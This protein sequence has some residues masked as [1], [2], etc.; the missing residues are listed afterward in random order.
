LLANKSIPLCK[1]AK[2]RVKLAGEVEDEQKL[3]IAARKRDKKNELDPDQDRILF[4]DAGVKDGW[5]EGEISD[6]G[7]LFSVDYD[8]VP[9]V[10][11]PVNPRE[12]A[13]EPLLVFDVK[14]EKSGVK[15]FM[16][17]LD[18]DFIVFD[19]VKKSSKVLCDLRNTP[20]A[21]TGKERQLRLLAR[22]HKGNESVFDTTIN[23]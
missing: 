1:K 6:L 3:F 2:I 7:D 15:T 12:W 16:G 9:P 18:D 13:N 23:Y 4:V 21:P 5:V 8:D 22:D 14:D 19:H 11:R 10:I 17:F 20:V